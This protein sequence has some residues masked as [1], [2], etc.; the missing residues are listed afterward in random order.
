MPDSNI[1][2]IQVDS[3]FK[4]TVPQAGMQQRTILRTGSIDYNG[5][6]KDPYDGIGDYR[7]EIWERDPSD[8][9]AW[10]QAK[11]NACEFGTEIVVP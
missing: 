10:T 5:S 4:R 6:S 9:N 1:Y 2:G 11:I 8:S 7:S 3:I